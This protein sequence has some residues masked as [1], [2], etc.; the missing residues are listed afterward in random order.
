MDR[1]DPYHYMAGDRPGM[2]LFDDPVG[3]A[4]AVLL[5]EAPAHLTLI[6]IM[7]IRLRSGSDHQVVDAGMRRKGSAEKDGL[8]DGVS[9]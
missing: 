5:E 7:R 4:D 9:R 1:S 6:N 2:L 3:G 8:R